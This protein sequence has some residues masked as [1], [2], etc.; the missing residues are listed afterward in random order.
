MLKLRM[1]LPLVI[2]MGWLVGAGC[3]DDRGV[4]D[5][6]VGGTAAPSAGAAGETATTGGAAAGGASDANDGGAAGATGCPADIFAAEGRA[7]AT[8]GM[9]CGDGNDDPCQFGQSIA[10]SG[11]KWQ[12]QEAF[13]APCGG[14]GGQ[15]SGGGAGAGDAAGGA[16]GAQ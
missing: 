15:P 13:P 6:G 16:A 4:V 9:V 3:D 8:D 14:A 10:C 2:L 1:G 5:M 7:C 12:H 11:G